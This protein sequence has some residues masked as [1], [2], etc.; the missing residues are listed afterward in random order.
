VIG[1]KVNGLDT[2][3]TPPSAGFRGFRRV[4]VQDSTI[5]KL[6]TWLFPKFSGVSNQ[7]SSVCN[8]RIQAVFDLISARLLAFS[9]DPYTRN[10]ISAAP[11]LGLV[12]IGFQSPNCS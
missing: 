6:P 8:A 5:V 12:Y 11:E 9:I 4:L 7:T 2:A 10:D 1:R 3:E